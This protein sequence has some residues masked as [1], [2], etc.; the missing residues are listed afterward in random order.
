MNDY[1]HIPNLYDEILKD[2]H[3]RFPKYSETP[4]PTLKEQNHVKSEPRPSTLP[5]RVR[6]GY[7][8]TAKQTD[9]RSKDSGC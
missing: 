8:Q 1:S 7:E 9:R 5:E 6:R 3:F 2:Y 4:Y